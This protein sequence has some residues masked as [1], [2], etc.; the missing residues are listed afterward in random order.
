M[1]WKKNWWSWIFMDEVVRGGRTPQVWDL[2]RFKCTAPCHQRPKP[3][4][5]R[6][7][8][9]VA[10]C[11]LVMDILL[12][13]EEFSL[14]ACVEADSPCALQFVQPDL[15]PFLVVTSWLKVSDLWW[16]IVSMCLFPLNSK[17]VTVRVADFSY[18]FQLGLHL[19]ENPPIGCA[20]LLDDCW[21]VSL[22]TT[23]TAY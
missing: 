5:S 22:L 2:R 18:N 20:I 13:T 7:E 16:T 3:Y 6:L 4:I 23:V 12:G 9:M 21:E 17:R 1:R 14:Y 8:I 10:R 19:L 11:R 15:P